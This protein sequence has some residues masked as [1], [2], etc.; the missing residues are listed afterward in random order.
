MSKSR[1][2]ML[3]CL[4]AI[5]LCINYYPAIAIMLVIMLTSCIKIAK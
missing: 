1:K 2:T 4:I 3:G 5:T